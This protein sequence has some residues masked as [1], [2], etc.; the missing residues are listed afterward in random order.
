M[1]HMFRDEA[2]APTTHYITLHYMLHTSK[3]LFANTHSHSA[4]PFFDLVTVKPR[5]SILPMLAQ[6]QPMRQT[7]KPMHKSSNEYALAPTD[8]LQSCS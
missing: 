2:A 5:P 4:H 3:Q 1:M 6:H 8:I 7:P